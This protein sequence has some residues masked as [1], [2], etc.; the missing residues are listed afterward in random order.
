MSESPQFVP[1]GKLTIAA[2]T[3]WQ[4]WI[5]DLGSIGSDDAELTAASEGRLPEA[6]VAELNA[7]IAGARNYLSA[8]VPAGVAEWMPARRA[9]S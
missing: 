4:V 5:Y 2:M 7:K 9:M 1:T 6:R 3:P 8:V